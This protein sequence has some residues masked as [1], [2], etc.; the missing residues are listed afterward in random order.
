M[1][2]TTSDEPGFQHLISKFDPRPPTN[3]DPRTNDNPPTNEEPPSGEEALTG[4]EAPANVGPPTDER[5]VQTIQEDPF[6]S[7]DEINLREEL[8]EQLHSHLLPLIQDQ[9]SALCHSLHPLG[10]LVKPKSTLRRLLR[11][12]SEIEPTMDQIQSI[13]TIV[14][15]KPIP[16]ATRTDDRHLRGLKAHRLHFL[17]TEF[18]E[19][20]WR[21]ICQTFG[22]AYEEIQQAGLSSERSRN[23]FDISSYRDNF[24]APTVLVH[25][26]IESALER[27]KESEFDY[28][29]H[30]WESA[31]PRIELVLENI[32]AML[33]QS[34]ISTNE[35]S[36]P[37]L[38]IPGPMIYLAKVA[39]PIVTLSRLFFAKLAKR[40]LN[41][42]RLPSLTEMSS[43]QIESLAKVAESVGNEVL[44]LTTLLVWV[45]G[46][47][48]AAH[49][50]DLIY[51]P[52][53]IS[54]LKMTTRVG[55][56]Y[57]I[58]HLS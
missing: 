33:Y 14:C 1:T 57:G 16:L 58:I 37:R 45:D 55:L 24:G 40:G 34:A 22:E 11:M 19:G 13:M 51:R 30:R 52:T 25:D 53:I 3:D 10:Y 29:K 44:K 32:N 27:L 31:I 2:D 36:L 4:E 41:K 23:Q 17:K 21:Y 48:A 35:D 47:R 20:W 7:F 46:G 38:F 56:L 6:L 9:M 54:L 39:L 43:D 15:P 18:D 42:E 26:S 28:V 49:S 8:L 50:R 5:P 12:Q